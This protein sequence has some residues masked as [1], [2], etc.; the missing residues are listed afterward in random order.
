MRMRLSRSVT[1]WPVRLPTVRRA[2]K[3]RLACWVTV[4]TY[5]SI[6]GVVHLLQDID[7]GGTDS[8]G[9]VTQ[10]TGS[11]WAALVDKDFMNL[12]ATVKEYGDT[13]DS[14][15]LCHRAFYYDVIEPIIL[16]SNGATARETRD[17]E[18]RSMPMFHGRPVMFAQVLP[19]AT[20]TTTVSC[21]FGDFGVGAMFGD[22]RQLSI[23]F[24][25]SAVV[26]GESVFE[27]DQLAVRGSQRYGITV[28]DAGT[29]TAAGAIVGLQ[30]GS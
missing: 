6:E 13:D 10:A 15:W 11:T 29:T 2:W 8:G 3:T 18:N 21:L 22:R 25:D 28:H 5:N 30:T 27:R 14:V 12:L 4:R 23:E 1:S 24:S 9:L 7:G 16:A 20:A 26:G 19:S 17:G